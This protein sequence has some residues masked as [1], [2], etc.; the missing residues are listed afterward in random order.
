[1]QVFS[2]QRKKYGIYS[3]SCFHEFVQMLLVLYGDVAD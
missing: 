2:T 1:M 3:N